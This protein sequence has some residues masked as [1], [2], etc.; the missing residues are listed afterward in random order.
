MW[1]HESDHGPE[2]GDLVVVIIGASSGIGRATAREFARR[3]ARLVLAARRREL[4][5]E[6]AHECE[7]LGAQA[8]AVPTD[9]TDPDAVSNLADAA[10]TSFGRIDVWVNNAGT[11]VFGPFTEGRIA[12]HRQVIEINLLGTMYGAAAALPIFQRQGH[13]VLINNISMGGWAPTPFAAAYTASKFG[14]RGFTSSLRQELKDHSGI[15]V[16]AV[17]PSIIDTPG[18]AHGANMSGR[19]L[20]L[21]GTIYPPEK[22]AEA[23]LGLVRRPRDEV[24]VG[25]PARAAQI[26]YALAPGPTE[27]LMGAAVRRYLRRAPPAPRTEGAVMHPVPYGTGAS[28]GLRQKRKS[29]IHLLGRSL[30]LAFLGALA[31]F[32]GAALARRLPSRADA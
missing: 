17:F 32:G 26:A 19:E 29:G 8:I 23:V 6:V 22:V 10:K 24:A 15:H 5:R 31:G 14:L 13:G 30:G 27:D 16:C 7:R 21:T 20:E 11:G 3:G 1:S 18:F 9:V 2:F 4:L 28:G 12:V 25:W